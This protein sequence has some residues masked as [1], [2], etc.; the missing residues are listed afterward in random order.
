MDI[1][2]IGMSC[3]DVIVHPVDRIDFSEDL[4]RVDN[5]QL[6]TGGD[7]LNVT[8]NISSLGCDVGFC[9]HI[10]DDR[11]GKLVLEVLREK[12]VVTD[13]VVVD[14]A[15]QTAMSINLVHS[16]GSRHFLFQGGG[17]YLLQDKDILV[18]ALDRARIVHIGG[19]FQ[20]PLYDGK[21][22]EN[23]LR[24]AKEHGKLTS[25]DV[26]WDNSGKWMET[27]GCCIPLLDYFIP[28]EEEAY[29]LTGEKDYRKMTDRFLSM[30]A[31]HVI[32]KCG[33]KG[34]YYKD[35]EIEY[36]QKAFKVNAVDTT[37][38]GDS[39]VGGFL[40]GIAKGL[41]TISCL[42]FAT[43]AAALCVQKMGSAAGMTAE[44]DVIDFLSTHVEPD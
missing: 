11:A 27:I 32:I 40:S 19:V 42:R 43:A 20:M 31:K 4:E 23:T 7:S 1:F 34:S 26:N 6:Q 37:G 29:Y 5:I 8:L 18:S 10:G 16:D 33:E 3:V 15:C 22:I 12:K 2:V 38:A 35:S 39:F 21:G 30:G 44:K 17:N 14:P 24:L 41:D 9:G 36:F 13:S 28:S 25:M